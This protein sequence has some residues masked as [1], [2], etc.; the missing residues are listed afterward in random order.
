MCKATVQQET[1]KNKLRLNA[2]TTYKNID[3][4]KNLL[5]LSSPVRQKWR[6]K[7]WYGARRKRGG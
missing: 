4:P 7:A 3:Q 2:H 5:N 1:P 6:Q